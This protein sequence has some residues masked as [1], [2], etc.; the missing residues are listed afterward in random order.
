MRG[1]FGLRQSGLAMS[2]PNIHLTVGSSRSLCRQCGA[3]FS[4]VG[5][6]DAHRRSFA[7][8]PPLDV[9]LVHVIGVW[10]RPD[11]QPTQGRAWI[12]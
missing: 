10:N 5:N 2:C 6:F 3:F 1:A 9:G 12:C 11:S 4:T 8:R 7:C